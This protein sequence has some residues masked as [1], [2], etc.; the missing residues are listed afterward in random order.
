VEIFFDLM[1]GA[2]LESLS[3]H[4]TAR[5]FDEALHPSGAT[6]SGCQRL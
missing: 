6:S 5:G 1:P 2:V 3:W 4:G